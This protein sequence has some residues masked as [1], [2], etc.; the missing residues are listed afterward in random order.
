[1]I[2][3]SPAYLLVGEGQRALPQELL[4]EEN[5]KLTYLKAWQTLCA[6][7]FW[8]SW[9]KDFVR[10]IQENKGSGNKDIKKR[11]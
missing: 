10:N 4:A 8:H 2:L 11:V 5:T 3:S 9:S 7:R 6:L 1:M